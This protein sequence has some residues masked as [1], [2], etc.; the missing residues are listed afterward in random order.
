MPSGGGEPRGEVSAEMLFQVSPGSVGALPLAGETH[1]FKN[2]NC[3][4]RGPASLFLIFVHLLREFAGSFAEMLSYR[5]RASE[6]EG[7]G[8]E[9]CAV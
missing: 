3:F 9:S 2:Q 4:H 1:L 6:V 7:S 5:Y 8:N